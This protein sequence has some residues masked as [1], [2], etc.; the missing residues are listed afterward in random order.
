MEYIGLNDVLVF[1]VCTSMLT[2]GKVGMLIC[3][4][5]VDKA[6]T[7]EITVTPV[8]NITYTPIEFFYKFLMIINYTLLLYLKDDFVQLLVQLHLLHLMCYW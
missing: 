3:V 5:G 7:V 1:F 8:L 4:V 2:D 6:I